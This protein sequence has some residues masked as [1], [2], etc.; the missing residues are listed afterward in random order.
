MSRPPL[1]YCVAS[2]A[3]A[4]PFAGYTVVRAAR[5]GGWRYL[6]ERLGWV[7]RRSDAPL[8]I[9]CASV[10]E[11]NAA[12]P[13]VRELAAHGHGPLL[14]TTNTPTGRRV[15]EARAPMG[16][17]CAYL[18]LDWPAPVRRFLGRTRPRAGIVME[19]ELWPWLFAAAGRRRVPLSLV[20]A[21]L[22][23][24]TLR[25]PGWL[26]SAFARC[27]QATAAILAR[28]ED[29][30]QGFRELGA[31]P[32]RVRVIGNIKFAAPIAAADTHIDLGRPFVLAAS[33]HDDEERQLAAAWMAGGD[34]QTLLVI[35][36]RHPDRGES[37]ADRLQDLGLTVVRRS[38]DE[39][40]TADT[41]IYLADTLGELPALIAGA[42]M[43][44]MGGSLVEHGGQNVLEPARAARAILTGPHMGNFRE[45]TA[46]L[47]AAGGL[48]Q[49][50]D[51]EEV[52][53]AA[54]DLLTDPDTR[55]DMGERAA[56]VL[57]AGADMAAR[58]REALEEG[59]L[60]TAR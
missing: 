9:H 11:I 25:A 33:T 27:L 18:P 1:A 22:S 36:P 8:W 44:I 19:T 28:S 17:D 23:T 5:D 14:L 24:R 37:I 56:G 46:A 31:P 45:E 35:A 39:R 2:A 58:Y 50:A 3:L 60:G 13:L 57:T 41:D 15:A 32:E 20:N 49:C 51:A 54:H 6:R 34:G 52:I 48:R 12:L 10:G 26:R 42:E 40:V 29:D 30:A 38:R 55:R 21:R 43:V 4:L 16:V 7:P 53:A 59:L 47:A